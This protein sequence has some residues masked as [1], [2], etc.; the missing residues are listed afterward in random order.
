MIKKKN[1]LD[2]LNYST[3]WEYCNGCKTVYKISSYEN[4]EDIFNKYFTNTWNILL[5]SRQRFFLNKSLTFCSFENFPPYTNNRNIWNLWFHAKSFV[6]TFMHFYLLMF[7][8]CVLCVDR[9]R[10]IQNFILWRNFS[11]TLSFHRNFV[12]QL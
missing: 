5:P 8:I 12:T 3:T 11:V 2:N 6:R 9:Y 7:F 10:K 4:I 1:C